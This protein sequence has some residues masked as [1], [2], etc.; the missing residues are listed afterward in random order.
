[1]SNPPFQVGGPLSPKLPVYV[2]RKADEQ[3]YEYIRRMDYLKLIETRQQGKTSLIYRLIDRFKNDN[4]V[5]AYFSMEILPSKQIDEITWY[6]YLIDRI[7][8]QLKAI[9]DVEKLLTPKNGRE[10]FNFLSDLAE[11]AGQANR[12]VV[13]VLDEIGGASSD[14]ATNFFSAMRSAHIHRP[15]QPAFEYLSFILAGAYNDRALIGDEN[16]SPFNVAQQV[17]LEDFNVEQTR[18][19]TM[20]LTDSS[21][22]QTLLA[23]H[24]HY[25]TDGQP[26]L[27]HWLC[28]ELVGQELTTVTVDLLIDK[29]CREDSNH[30]PHVFAFSRNKVLKEYIKRIAD[31]NIVSFAP[32]YLRS[33]M[34]LA[35]MGIIK[36][37]EGQCKIRNRLYQRAL[38]DILADTS[39][40]I[41]PLLNPS[42]LDNIRKLIMEHHARLHELRMQKAAGG[43]FTDPKITIEITQIEQE[44]E[45]LE[46]QRREL[47]GD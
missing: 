28:R 10:W 14:W 24:I 34:K 47:E 35:L 16:I 1:M 2:E 45:E 46:R 19:L 25:W 23:E 30:L 36:G 8:L 41:E 5:F 7:L 31:G 39:E 3:A 12:K 6:T 33:Q 21:E 11:L 44:V 29:F 18:L 13:I 22:A 43:I 42:P 40:E 32:G 20:Y 37:I 38:T 4:Y 26:Y 15:I 9:P 17:H 27:T